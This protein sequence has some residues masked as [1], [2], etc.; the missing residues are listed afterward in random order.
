M[1]EVDFKVVVHKLPGLHLS[2]SLLYA[3]GSFGF[4]ESNGKVSSPIL[5][6]KREQL[7]LGCLT[8]FLLQHDN[9]NQSVLQSVRLE[10]PHV[11]LYLMPH[12][13]NNLKF[14]LDISLR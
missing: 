1:S 10:P 5:Q 14:T 9:Q 3:L 13:I 2:D 4:D 12:T 11:R 8:F 7:T 6:T